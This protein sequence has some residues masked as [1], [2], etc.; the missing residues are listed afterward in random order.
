VELVSTFP[1]VKSNRI[2]LVVTGTPGNISRI[3]EVE[4]YDPAPEE[5]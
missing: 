2:R 3:W 5:E 4:L 1:A